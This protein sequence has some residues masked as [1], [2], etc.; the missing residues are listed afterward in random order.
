[1]NKK[2]TV[3]LLIGV[4]IGFILGCLVSAVTN[5]EHVK[6]RDCD[7]RVYY[8]NGPMVCEVYMQSQY[9]KYRIEQIN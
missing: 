3:S 8:M 9:D 1:M 7:N 5:T 4:S 6:T 2:Q